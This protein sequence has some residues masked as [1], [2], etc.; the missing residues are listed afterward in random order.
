MQVDAKL[1]RDIR[2]ATAKDADAL[3]TKAQEFGK[4]IRVYLEALYAK[5]QMPQPAMDLGKKKAD[6][7]VEILRYAVLQAALKGVITTSEIRQ[8]V[9][10]KFGI[11]Y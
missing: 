3:R 4:A 5:F 7:C 11:E 1:H 2:W 6:E 9:G 8:F 10:E